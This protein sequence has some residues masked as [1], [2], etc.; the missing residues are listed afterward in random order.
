ML[1][2]LQHSTYHCCW[3]LFPYSA[4]NLIEV[5]NRNIPVQYDINQVE[6]QQVQASKAVYA[7][8]KV[9]SHEKAQAE[10][11]KKYYA[12]TQ[13]A[14]NF[15]S[16]QEKSAQ[17]KVGE[18]ASQRAKA[19][20]AQVKA[21]EI[22]ET[23]HKVVR[24]AITNVNNARKVVAFA[25]DDLDHAQKVFDVRT[26]EFEEA[27]NKF[28]NAEA[29]TAQ[30]AQNAKAALTAALNAQNVYNLAF[31]TYKNA[32]KI[33][34]KALDKKQ[35]S[36]L[37]V[38]AARNALNLAV[39]VN[40]E[41]HAELTVAHDV[42]KKS[43]SALDNANLLVSQLRAKLQ[44]S[45]DS[46]G[47]AKFNLQQANNNLFV[48]QARK[49]QA[50][51]A[52]AIVRSQSTTLP[53]PNASST[54]IF[55]GCEQH[56]YPTITGADIVGAHNKYGYKLKSGYTLLH[57]SCTSASKVV[58]ADGDLINYVGYLKDGYVHATSYHKLP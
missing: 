7:A 44:R 25:K 55:G 3:Y 10:D 29:Q 2:Y 40:D 5:P 8:I 19:D 42:Y 39:Q 43:Y 32:K 20:A 9:V 53:D 30:A 18:A 21:H 22:L 16:T 17:V 37:V 26:Q 24:L 34:A 28:I 27:N 48:A 13:L 1:L 51:K 47:V 38:N 58:V 12:K 41:A 50:D 6:K 36:D 46:L 56:G 23:A 33:L 57:G 45:M 54:Y 15:A 31:K 49:A 35:Q 4:S 11:A 14:L 52:T